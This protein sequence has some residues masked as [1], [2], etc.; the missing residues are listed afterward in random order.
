MFAIL[1]KRDYKFKANIHKLFQRPSQHLHTG[2][3]HEKDYQF[4]Q[5]F[6]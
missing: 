4:L 5:Q 3:E 6:L 1:G 2:P